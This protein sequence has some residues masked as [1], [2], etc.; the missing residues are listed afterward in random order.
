MKTNLFYHGTN[1]KL[2]IGDYLLPPIQTNN[3]R[4]CWRTKHNDVVFI[5]TSLSSAKKYAKKS[6][7]QDT[8]N[9]F[10]YL[11]KPIPYSS[12]INIQHNEYICDKAIIVDLIS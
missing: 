3:L 6:A 1:Q 2:E 11:V 5:T 9:T 10:V 7:Q 4:E 12:L 8:Q